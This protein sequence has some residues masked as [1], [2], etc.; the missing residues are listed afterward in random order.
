MDSAVLPERPA[1]MNSQPQNDQSADLPGLESARVAAFVEIPIPGI[2]AYNAGDDL[3]CYFQNQLQNSPDDFG[4]VLDLNGDHRRSHEILQKVTIDSV[5]IS[6]ESITVL[7]TVELSVFNACKDHTDNYR[8]QR[9]AAGTQIGDFWRFNR[10]VPLPERSSFD[11][12]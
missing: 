7:Y 1:V 9:S 11:E 4:T 3:R 8:F 5:S 12:L 10:H 2:T 6:G